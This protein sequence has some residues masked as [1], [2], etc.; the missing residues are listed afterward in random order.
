MAPKTIWAWA[1]KKRRLTFWRWIPKSGRY[2][3][4]AYGMVLVFPFFVSLRLFCVGPVE[5]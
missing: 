2:V 1:M 3:T 5:R 4:F